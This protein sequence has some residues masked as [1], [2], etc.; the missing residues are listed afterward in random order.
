LNTDL[1]YP[2]GRVQLVEYSR[3]AKNNCLKAIQALPLQLDYA[4]K[5]F[6]DAHLHTPYRDGGWTPD[7]I[8]HHLADSHMNA[9]KRFKLALHEEHPPLNLMIKM[10]GLKQSM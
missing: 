2:F 4:I 5:N 7:Q 6:N 8:I 9:F 3:S 10:Y 1:Q